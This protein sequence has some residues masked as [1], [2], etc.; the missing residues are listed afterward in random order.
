MPRARV[1]AVHG[2]LSNR[3]GRRKRAAERARA[4][5]RKPVG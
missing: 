2:S 1:R 3:R 4:T 5:S